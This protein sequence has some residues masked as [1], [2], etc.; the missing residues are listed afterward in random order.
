MNKKLKGF[1][2]KVIVI[3]IISIILLC[4]GGIPEIA[5]VIDKLDYDVTLN[6]NGS[7][8]ITETWDMYISRTNT[9][10]KT[11][12]RESYKYKDITDVT[13]KDL[14]TNKNLNKINEEMYHVTKDCY[15]ALKNK[16]GQFEIA[17]GIGMDKKIGKRKFQIQ[18]TVNDVVADYY[19]LQEFYWKFIGEGQNEI[20]VKKI[21]GRVRLP[22]DVKNI[23]NIKIWGH[24]PLNGEINKVSKNKVEFK[25]K[26]LKPGQMFEVRVIT[27]DKMFKCSDKK[28]SKFNYLKQILKEE[29][30]WAN[31]SN[32]KRQVKK[33]F[34]GI[35]LGI[36][37]ILII[38]YI[39][40]IKKYK[41][42]KN[43]KNKRAKKI[44]YYRDIPRQGNSTPAEANY[45]YKFNK[46]R[47]STKEVQNTSVSATILDLCLKKIIGLRVDGDKVYIRILKNPENLK[48]DELEIYKLLKEVGKNKEE[49]EI[50][51][52]ND[53]AN[54]EYKKY[55]DHINKL[56]NSTRNNLYKMKLIDKA[57]EKRYNKYSYAESKEIIVRNIFEW[58]LVFLLVSLIPL[59]NIMVIRKLG[60]G[61][62]NFSIKWIIILAPIIFAKLYIWKLQLEISN[63]IAVL[64][65]EGAEEKE[66]W[67][68]LKRYMENFSLIE[69]REIPE[70]AL[71]EEYL[72]YATAFGIAD[73]VIEQ[74]KA[75]YPKVFVKEKWEEG[76]IENM[77]LSNF[78]ILN[79]S[80]S[81][82]PVINPIGKI[83]SI[84]DKAYNSS[85]TQ[86]SLHSSSDS[87]GGGF[88][89]GGG[90]RR[91]RRPEWEVVNSK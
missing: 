74:M 58:I 91:R 44:D 85:M 9:L 22:K 16:R 18:Y 62:F 61:Y 21:T 7:A 80:I 43:E 15:Y 2:K 70:L 72:V 10:F 34:I 29:Q 48:E 28:I 76:N 53:Y 25:T 45:L 42:I 73:K 31:E 78:P 11:F 1:L 51:E 66:K 41:N 14:K 57:N 4:L 54:K 20:P 52:I 47:L 65:E 81:F 49:F 68:G 5:Q 64:T 3:A 39:F 63:K 79:F 83:D 71:W 36:Y 88:S 19:D 87:D 23:E 90:G 27:T 59:F 8:T 26:N 55:S 82:D 32:N 40:K 69:E 24:G 89:G 13:V 86:I 35:C 75:L 33:T 60:V 12:Q 38:V 50:E 37:V 17:W 46:E 84:S 77:D 30:K 56:V 67:K 6:E